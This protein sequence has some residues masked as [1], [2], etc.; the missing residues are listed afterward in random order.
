[1][2]KIWDWHKKVWNDSTPLFGFNFEDD[3]YGNKD[4]KMFFG[5]SKI[6]YTER[7]NN[8]YAKKVNPGVILLE[9]KKIDILR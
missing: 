8:G 5:Q 1:M 2:G 6:Q 9:K 7:I 4:F 3:G